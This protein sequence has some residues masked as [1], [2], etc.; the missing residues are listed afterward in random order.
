MWAA[1]ELCGRPATE[2][3]MLEWSGDIGSDI[4]VFFSTGAAYCTG[5]GEIVEVGAPLNTP[6]NPLTPPEHPLH[7]PCTTAEYPLNTP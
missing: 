2:E 3:Q 4:S 1:N 6:F 5:R 7:T